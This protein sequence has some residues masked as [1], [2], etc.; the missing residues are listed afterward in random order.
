M[1]LIVFRII[2]KTGR[3]DDGKLGQ[4]RQAGGVVSVAW[5]WGSGRGF[6]AL[7][8]LVRRGGKSEGDTRVARVVSMRYEGKG[9]MIPVGG[10]GSSSGGRSDGR[11]DF[12]GRYRKIGR[13]RLHTN[14]R[15]R[16]RRLV[17]E[18]EW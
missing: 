7:A 14:R 3:H 13:Y 9:R 6:P 15:S 8:G 16:L 12:K 4:R 1:G 11:C 2:R 10:W 17:R 18:G 5:G